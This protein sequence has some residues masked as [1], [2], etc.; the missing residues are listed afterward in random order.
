MFWLLSLLVV[1]KSALPESWDGF[2]SLNQDM[3]SIKVCSA[4]TDCSCEF[5]KLSVLHKF[6]IEW[7]HNQIETSTVTVLSCCMLVFLVIY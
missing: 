6:L 3:G 7:V 5:S 4:V 1:A 2:I